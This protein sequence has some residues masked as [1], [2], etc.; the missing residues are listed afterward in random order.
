MS[1]VRVFSIIHTCVWAERKRGRAWEREKGACEGEF[2]RGSQRFLQARVLF[3]FSGR[4]PCSLK[5]LEVSTSPRRRGSLPASGGSKR[6][7]GS[8]PASGGSK[9]SDGSLPAS[10][11][12]WD[13]S[14]FESYETDAKEEVTN[15][16]LLEDNHLDHSD[17]EEILVYDLLLFKKG[18]CWLFPCI[19]GFFYSA[20]LFRMGV[21]IL[22][23]LFRTGIL[24]LRKGI[25]GLSC[26][27]SSSN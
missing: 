27:V 17:Q 13:D 20:N 7:V 1:F 8:L 10:E 15:L 2:M 4:L 22:R 6:S 21:L 25:H 19:G 18:V 12:F 11:D 23:L 14:T 9:R 3:V 26:W 5:A 24:Q 16:C